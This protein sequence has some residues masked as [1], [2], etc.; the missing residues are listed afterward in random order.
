MTYRGY[1]K[2]SGGS[3]RL[4]FVMPGYDANDENV[5][6]NKVIFDSDNIG[7]LSILHSG[8]YTWP[9]S[10]N[11][12]AWVRIA[13]WSPLPFVPL[14]HFLFRAA[15]PSEE[16][17][18]LNFLPASFTG[19]NAAVRSATLNNMFRITK[20]GIDMKYY[21]AQQNMTVFWYAFNLAVA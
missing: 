5:P 15:Y 7:T 4:R 8:S 13:S 18:T 11:T 16:V 9:A 17:R 12:D 19:A 21:A 20:S 3:K 14:C 10:S 2:D 6:P 1:L